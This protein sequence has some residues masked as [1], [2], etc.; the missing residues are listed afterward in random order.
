MELIAGPHLGC[1]QARQARG[2]QRLCGA[3][4]STG[5]FLSGRVEGAQSLGEPEGAVGLGA[6][7]QEA[8]GLP[9]Q[10]AVSGRRQIRRVGDGPGPPPQE[11][12]W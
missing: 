12:G 1:A 7:G 2:G 9:A 8:A 10:M 5:Q 3:T 11:P 6:V 4:A